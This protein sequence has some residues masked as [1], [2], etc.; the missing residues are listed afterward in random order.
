MKKKRVKSK[1][2][3][4]YVLPDNFSFKSAVWWVALIPISMIVSSMLSGV[5][6]QV[7]MILCNSSTQYL[8]RVVDSYYSLM[9]KC[10]LADGSHQLYTQFQLILVAL[11]WMALSYVKDKYEAIKSDKKWEDERAEILT[12][13][14][15][16]Q[17]RILKQKVKQ[18][19]KE[20]RKTMG[21]LAT[22]IKCASIVIYPLAAFILYS[23]GVD[24]YLY[25]CRKSFEQR[26]EI[27]KPLINQQEYDDLN[28]AWRL[29]KTR[30]DF[31]EIKSRLDKIASLES[32]GETK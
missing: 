28:R 2:W 21:F 4:R 18:S 30:N 20:V 15:E 5:V 16:E 31:V 7:K 13:K 8:V 10:S 19:E 29:M 6:G 26:M 12:K 14:E 1:S 22:A 24:A 3:C 11:M 17:V 23:T 9:A 25:G 32:S 27:I